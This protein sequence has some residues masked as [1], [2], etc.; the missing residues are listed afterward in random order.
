MLPAFRNRTR[1]AVIATAARLGPAAAANASSRR[2]VVPHLW[3]RTFASAG[4]IPKDQVLERVMVV[5]KNYQGVDQSKVAPTSHFM[6]DLGLD[7]LDVVEVR[8]FPAPF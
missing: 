4:F 1:A 6:N 3:A 8:Q 7:S 5:V 2:A